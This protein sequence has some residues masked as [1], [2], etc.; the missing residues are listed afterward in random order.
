MMKAFLKE[1]RGGPVGGK[2]RR[3]ATGGA[4]FELTDS[5]DEGENL[6]GREKLPIGIT[7]NL[8]RDLIPL[9]LLVWLKHSA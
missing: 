1:K 7:V 9:I 8:V 5:V 3:G 2:G 6:E 4:E